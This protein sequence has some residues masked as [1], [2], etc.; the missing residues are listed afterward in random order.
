MYESA[1]CQAGTIWLMALQLYQRLSWWG[2]Y[3]PI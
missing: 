2:S 1:G 3:R